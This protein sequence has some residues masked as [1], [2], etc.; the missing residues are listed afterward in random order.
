MKRTDIA[1]QAT[2]ATNWLPWKNDS[3][4]GIAPR[5]ASNIPG[6]QMSAY[7]AKTENPGTLRPLPQ[8]PI[9]FAP[10]GCDL[11]SFFFTNSAIR[12]TPVSMSARQVA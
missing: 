4:I 9:D 1:T 7:A 11:R 10:T 6:M 8:T 5:S 3:W 12:S 2:Q